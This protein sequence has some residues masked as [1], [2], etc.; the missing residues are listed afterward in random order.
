[1][2]IINQPS[3][4]RFN[5]CA[6]PDGVCLGPCGS[7][8]NPTGPASLSFPHTL[9]GHAGVGLPSLS[10]LALSSSGPWWAAPPNFLVEGGF[11][12]ISIPGTLPIPLLHCAWLWEHIQSHPAAA[13]RLRVGPGPR[14]LGVGAAQEVSP[15]CTFVFRREERATAACP[16]LSAHSPH[17]PLATSHAH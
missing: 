11:S 16:G 4:P 7:S 13:T 17:S 8:S 2:I 14:G 3:E 10:P 12:P 5:F 1:M 6:S 9:I 15:P